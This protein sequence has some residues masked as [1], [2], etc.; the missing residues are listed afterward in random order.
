MPF[1][2]I[3]PTSLVIFHLPLCVSLQYLKQNAGSSFCMDGM[4]GA[5]LAS[6]TA[7]NIS[8]PACTKKET[9]I[10]RTLKSAEKEPSLRIGSSL[11]SIVK[12][13]KVDSSYYA[14]F[15]SLHDIDND[16]NEGNKAFHRDIPSS[17]SNIDTGPLACVVC[18]V[19]GFAS[20]AIIQ[21]CQEAAS[22]F[23]ST[24]YEIGQNYFVTDGAAATNS[25]K[26]FMEYKNGLNSK[27]VQLNQHG[28]GSGYKN[29]YACQHVAENMDLVDVK[30]VAL[31]ESLEPV[32]KSSVLFSES[33]NRKESLESS[34]PND[35]CTPN[36]LS[37]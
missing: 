34:I 29:T 25:E 9:C 14:K 36:D 1:Y 12:Q 2:G 10:E 30:A 21:P 37:V 18:G 11:L 32:E 5:T 8:T 23:F 3:L 17:E 16:N 24:N 22:I 19:L 28:D 20:M 35:T 13:E 33:T 6:E 26:H 27:I 31:R 7:L 4:V 15:S